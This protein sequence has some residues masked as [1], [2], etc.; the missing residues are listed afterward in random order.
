[1]NNLTSLSLSDV[2]WQWQTGV[3]AAWHDYQE[4]SAYYFRL[5]GMN[6]T[7]DEHLRG[8]RG[9]HDVDV[10]V[11][12]C[13][14]GIKQIWIVECK[15]WR[16]RVGKLYVNALANVVQ[17]VGADKG[18]LLSESGFQSGAVESASCSNITLTSLSELT[19]ECCIHWETVV[20]AGPG[21]L[22]C[23]MCGMTQATDE[24]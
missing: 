11:R 19:A 8:V 13:Q 6:A 7:V 20:K 18:I 16:R 3:M 15:L 22:A 12:T 21:W 4:R 17:D 24:E 2:T 23:T 9:E 1:M 5:L 10:V 14:A